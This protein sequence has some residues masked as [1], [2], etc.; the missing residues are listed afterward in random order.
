MITENQLQSHCLWLAGAGSERLD[1]AGTSHA[2]AAL[3]YTDLRSADLSDTDFSDANL[4]GANMRG[5]NLRGA[6]LRRAN[7]SNTD[8]READFSNTDLR[9]ASLQDATLGWASFRGAA[10]HGANLRGADMRNCD[11]HGASLQ[12]VDLRGADLRGAFFHDCGLRGVRIDGALFDPPPVP[13]TGNFWCYKRLSDGTIAKLWVPATAARTGCLQSRK[14]RVEYALVLEGSGADGAHHSGVSYRTG[15]WVH[16]D[17]YDPD[18]RVE[19][20]HGI[21]V[22]ATKEE[23]RRA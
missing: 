8:L 23:A 20:T 19:C 11:L 6:V 7:L 18:L 12:Y 22:Y 17:S 2:G 16:P 5:A 21:H 14:C 1:V 10:Y 15:E 3:R 13:D 9:G 4:H